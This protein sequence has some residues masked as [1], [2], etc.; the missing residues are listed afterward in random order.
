MI[1]CF[2][3]SSQSNMLTNWFRYKKHIED[4]F[5][6]K[7]CLSLFYDCNKDNGLFKKTNAFNSSFNKLFLC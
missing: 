2:T 7:N 1:M 5:V 6:I 3:S 4:P